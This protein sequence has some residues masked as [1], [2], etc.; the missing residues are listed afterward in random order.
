ASMPLMVSSLADTVDSDPSRLSMTLTPSAPLT[1]AC[2]NA[3]TSPKAA[4]TTSALAGNAAS[5]SS[6]PAMSVASPDVPA[7]SG[8]V[9]PGRSPPSWDGPLV[10]VI[11][12]SPHR[13]PFPPGGRSAAG[14]GENACGVGDGLPLRAPWFS[15]LDGAPGS[16]ATPPARETHRAEQPHGTTDGD[17]DVHAVGWRG[18]GLGRRRRLDGGPS[19][20][21]RADPAEFGEAFVE[22]VD[23]QVEVAAG[24]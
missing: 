11:S 10:A 8:V 13:S 3:T 12:S 5:S 9:L 20:L 14:G 4:S 6:R 18:L 15:H 24:G 21:K 17:G 19:A 16:G 23:D 7:T 2:A 1:V 22:G